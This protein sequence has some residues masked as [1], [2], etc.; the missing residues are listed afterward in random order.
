LRK[1]RP[2]GLPEGHPGGLSGAR[3]TLH[4]GGDTP[5]RNRI[6]QNRHVPK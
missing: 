3:T 4:A 5:L 6:R 1:R 2:F